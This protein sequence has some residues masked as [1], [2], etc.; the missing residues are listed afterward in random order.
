MSISSPLPT[1]SLQANAGLIALAQGSTQTLEARVL[2]LLADGLTQVQIGTQTLAL[3]LPAPQ[4]AGTVLTLTVQQSNGQQQVVLTSVTPPSTQAALP[5]Q[6]QAP[7]AT[8][9]LSPAALASNALAQATVGSQ[10]QSAAPKN[11]ALSETVLV[12]T[13]PPSQT[14]VATASPTSPIAA[15]SA[16]SGLEKANAAPPPPVN[17]TAANTVPASSTT[18][19]APNILRS[20]GAPAPT[21]MV[22]TGTPAAAAPAAPIVA[23]IP[24]AVVRS[25]MSA[26]PATATKAGDAPLMSVAPASGSAASG[27]HAAVADNMAKVA[28]SAAQA[29]PSTDQVLRATL[30]QMVQ[31][32]LPRQDSIV[33]LTTALA[34]LAGRV[35]M[36]EPVSRAARQVLAQTTPIDDPGL[37][38]QT[39]KSAVQRSGILQESLLAAGDGKAASADLKSALL[40]LRQVLTRWIGDQPPVEHLAAVAPPLRGQFPRAKHGIAADEPLPAEPREAGKV[41]LERTE[42]ALSRIRLHQNTS[43]PEPTDQATKT[44]ALWSLDLPVTIAGNQQMLQL[45]IHHD[46]EGQGDRPEDR[47]WQ[48]RFAMHLPADGEVGAQISL[49]GKI[50]GVMVWAEDPV[51]AEALSSAVATL[52]ADLESAG[53]HPGTVVVRSGAPRNAA[54]TTPSSGQMLDAVR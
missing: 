32:A 21:T 48:V 8:V 46:A 6:T 26:A 20:D 13:S 5:F 40:G 29:A 22:V 54:S 28:L 41:L 12:Q 15:P 18:V 10:A 2:A 39:I 47:G 19:T 16:L 27:Q 51:T 1:L 42:G 50:T 45:Q 4:P 53:L 33:G 35:S 11:M 3:Q 9:Q 24:Y 25:A 49:R 14:A 52:R 17:V 36:P 30:Q 37:D 23:P 44:G 38:G 7:A 31:Q 43:L 34:A